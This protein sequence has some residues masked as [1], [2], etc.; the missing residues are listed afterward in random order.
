[1]R[2][3]VPIFALLLAMFPQTEQDQVHVLLIGEIR[4][5][6]VKGDQ[7]TDLWLERDITK[8]VEYNQIDTLNTYL[9]WL[10]LVYFAGQ[11]NEE[12]YLHEQEQFRDFLEN[13]TQKPEKAFLASFL[14]KW[15]L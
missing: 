13:E 7:V 3:P 2:F 6:D 8:I 15:P 1:M 11:I 5:I 14:E 4:K 12:D 10:R 9:V